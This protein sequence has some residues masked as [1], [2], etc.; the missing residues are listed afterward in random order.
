[1]HRS[2]RTGFT[3]IELMIAASIIGIL[4]MIAIPKFADMVVKAK[5]AAVK[6]KLGSLRSAITIY[7]SDTEGEY[8]YAMIGGT[9]SLDVLTPKYID[10]IPSISIPRLHPNAGNHVDLMPMALCGNFDPPNSFVWYVG[11][12]GVPII[13]DAIRVNCAQTD[14]RG[15]VWSTY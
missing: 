13:Y 12:S 4:A 9:H 14:S 11:A 10:V 6:G 5:E 7:Y 2:L 8:P 3:L 1:M 15:S